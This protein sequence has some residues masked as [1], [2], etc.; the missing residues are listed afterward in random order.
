[1]KHEVSLE[2]SFPCYRGGGHIGGGGDQSEILIFKIYG[3][4]F[5][6]KR[7]LS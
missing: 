1:M 3:N 5:Y 2:S 6:V 4:A 7:R